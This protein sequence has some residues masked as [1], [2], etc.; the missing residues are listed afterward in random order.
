MLSKESLG[1][2]VEQH[3]LQSITKGNLKSIGKLMYMT[4]LF[5]W[6]SD[7]D[8]KWSTNGYVFKLFGGVDSWMSRRQLIFKLL[9]IEAEY[10]EFTHTS[11]EKVWIWRLCL[12]VRF[13]QK[14]VRINCDS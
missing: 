1:T 3:I 11:K 14:V 10:M 9:T 12:E 13:K 2:C 8:H 7:L 4:L 5:D 6:A